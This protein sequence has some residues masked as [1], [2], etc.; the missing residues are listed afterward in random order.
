MYSIYGQRWSLKSK[1]PFRTEQLKLYQPVKSADPSKR[2]KV[3]SPTGTVISCIS[4]NHLTS[5]HQVVSKDGQAEVSCQGCQGGLDAREFL[6][7]ACGLCPEVA[8]S[9]KTEDAVGV[10]AKYVVPAGQQVVGLN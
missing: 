6:G 4:G 2:T 1:Q 10:V 8:E 5:R 7:E 3:R 9:A